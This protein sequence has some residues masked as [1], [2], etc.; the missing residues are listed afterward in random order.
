M[1]EALV[2]RRRTGC[3]MQ[4]MYSLTSMAALLA[5]TGRTL[6]AAVLAGAAQQACA[7]NGLAVDEFTRGLASDAL[8]RA[9]QTLPPAEVDRASSQGAR[10]SID[11]AVALALG[12]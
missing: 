8:V 6:D 2:L 3:A 5:R 12:A 1:R 11:E 4:L 10:M 9:R 7:A